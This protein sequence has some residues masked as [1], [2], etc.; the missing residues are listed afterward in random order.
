M[1]Q[2]HDKI[3]ACVRHKIEVRIRLVRAIEQ[4]KSA[5]FD[6]FGQLTS[7]AL[8]AADDSE[9]VGRAV[10][11]VEM[12]AP[13]NSPARTVLVARQCP[14]DAA[15]DFE[16]G[17]IN[18]HNL[19]GDGVESR[20]VRQSTDPT[21]EVIDQW[22][23]EGEIENTLGIGK[24]ALG[25]TRQLQAPAGDVVLEHVFHGAQTVNSRIE[26]GEK[27]RDDDM[28]SQQRSVAM[29]RR[30]MELAKLIVEQTN[31]P[32]PHDRFSRT[33]LAP[34][35]RARFSRPV[36]TPG[37]RARFSPPSRRQH[38]VAPAGLDPMAHPS[39]TPHPTQS[40]NFKI[41]LRHPS[42]P[43][44]IPDRIARRAVAPGGCKVIIARGPW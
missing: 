23:Q 9:S 39:S 3:A 40:R 28:V 5:W 44:K 22:L 4:V 14:C 20:V 12:Q 29:D 42:L 30:A 16:Y 31:Q 15:G 18:S 26:K 25:N 43:Q 7:L 21:N 38:N 27:M 19:F 35:F 24:G 11:H 13:L 6:G 2:P 1:P 10:K 41:V 34:G 32:T 17:S 33:V 37:F 8:L 36:F